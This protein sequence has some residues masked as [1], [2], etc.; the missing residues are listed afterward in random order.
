MS[1]WNRVKVKTIAFRNPIIKTSY[2]KFLDTIDNALPKTFNG[3]FILKFGSYYDL[4][5]IDGLKT[6]KC[7]DLT[8]SGIKAIKGYFVNDVLK[9]CY[10]YWYFLLLHL[11]KELIRYDVRQF[12][13]YLQT[14]NYM[15]NHGCFISSWKYPFK[16]KPG[17]LVINL[18][19]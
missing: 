6:G 11:W 1:T 18:K 10:S 19:T 2:S 16:T 7:I 13:V 15:G 3:A 4:R 8:D 5:Y 12:M 17:Y 9:V 14:F